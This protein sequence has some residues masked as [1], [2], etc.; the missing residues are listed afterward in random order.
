MLA[1]TEEDEPQLKILDM[2]LALL[3]EQRKG[4][5]RDLTSTGQMMGTLDYMAPEQGMDSHEV[6][7]RADIYSLGATLYKLLCGEAPFSNE[8]YNTPVKMLM[9]LGMETAPSI[10]TKRDDLAPELVAIVDRMLAKQ[11]EDRFATPAEVAEALAPFAEGANLAELAQ[12]ASAAASPAETTE[13]KSRST[14][15]HASSALLDTTSSMPAAESASSNAPSPVP[16]EGRGEGKSNSRAE[17]NALPQ[18]A[19]SLIID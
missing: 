5:R 14:D 7:I 2:G 15:P 18:P 13:H 4:E 19:S 9:A 8:K 6:E 11:P 3:D 16:G 12:R 1:T 10:A 17:S